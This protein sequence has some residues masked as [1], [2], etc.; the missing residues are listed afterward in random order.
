MITDP[1]ELYR[2]LAKPGIEVAALVFASD[3]IVCASWRYIDEEKVPNLPHT[4]EVLGAMSLIAR[5]FVCIH[6]SPG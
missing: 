3:K 6:N 5:E 1:Q 4:N 2:F